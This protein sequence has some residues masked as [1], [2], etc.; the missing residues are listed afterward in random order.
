MKVLSQIFESL[1]KVITPVFTGAIYFRAYFKV[2][3][4][5]LI[6]MTKKS[7]NLLMINKLFV[8]VANA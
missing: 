7:E 5:V 1:E 4:N 3:C 6:W 2:W 8:D